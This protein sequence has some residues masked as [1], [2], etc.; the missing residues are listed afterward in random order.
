[1]KQVSESVASD[2]V[3]PPSNYLIAEMVI[4]KEE[5]RFFLS[6]KTASTKGEMETNGGLGSMAGHYG[7]YVIATFD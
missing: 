3:S 4:T 1:M 2:P 7:T 6:I 5:P